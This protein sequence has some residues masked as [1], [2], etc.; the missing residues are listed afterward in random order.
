MRR[1]RLSPMGIVGVA[2][3]LLTVIVAVFAPLIAP[4]DPH[5]TVRVTI[6]GHLPATFR[7]PLAGHRR[8]RQGRLLRP[9]LRVE[10]VV[11]RRVRRRLHRIWSWAGRWV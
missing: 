6:Y 8:R 4:Y 10:G 5:E 7:P 11:D 1:F 9:R 3:V 2:M